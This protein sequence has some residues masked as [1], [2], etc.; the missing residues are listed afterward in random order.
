MPDPDAEFDRYA[1]DYDAALA[2]GL[3]VSGESKD[4][5]AQGRIAFLAACLRRL[6]DR[7]SSPAVLDFGCGTGSAT[8]FLQNLLSARTVLGVDVSARSLSVARRTFGS[9]TVQFSAPKEAT[10]HAALDLAFCNGVFHHIPVEARA[11]AI[12]YLFHSLRPGGLFAFWENNPWN[13]GTRLVMDRCPFDGDAVTLA[14]P[15]AE[16]LLRAGGFQPLRTDF[17]FLFPRALR[18]LRPLELPLSRLPLGAQYQ[19]LCRK[20]LDNPFSCPV[21]FP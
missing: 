14:P 1:E 3:S 18:R 20:P 21:Y 2:Q 16:R 11:E 15:E 17:L 10:P 4:Y 12:S 7:V 8:P 19:V 5:F 9:D 13:P 6:P